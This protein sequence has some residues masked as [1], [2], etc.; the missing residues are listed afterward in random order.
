MEDNPI[1]PIG[2]TY[3]DL[4]GVSS[5]QSDSYWSGNGLGLTAETV[6]VKLLNNASTCDIQ[7]SGSGPFKQ[8]FCKI[9]YA[10]MASSSMHD[11]LLY[12]ALGQQGRF[13]FALMP[14]NAGYELEIRVY[15]K[16]LLR[17]G[18]TTAESQIVEAANNAINEYWGAPS[19]FNRRNFELIS[20]ADRSII[21]IKPRIV[22][23]ISDDFFFSVTVFPDSAS[24][25]DMAPHFE[26]VWTS[27]FSWNMRE[28]FTFKPRQE[29]IHA[30]RGPHEY[31]H[32]MGIPHDVGDRET[33]MSTIEMNREAYMPWKYFRNDGSI[34]FKN[35]NVPYGGHF[36]LAKIW[37]EIVF[38]NKL[39]RIEDFIIRS[40]YEALEF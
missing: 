3:T 28:T 13:E 32:M 19:G 27:D 37:T 12:S 7:G 2:N 18:V 1:T 30:G 39:N 31:G 38:A 20:R 29:S 11:K 21:P 33:I 10:S 15:W 8:R 24:D 6:L 26:V 34:D 23:N 16:L 14:V 17:P 40:P 25:D 35:R 36:K 5:K 4:M 22:N 9:N